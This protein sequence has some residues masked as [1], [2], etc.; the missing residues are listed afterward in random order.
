M[1]IN[2]IK[3]MKKLNTKLNAQFSLFVKQWYA[4]AVFVLFGF[5]LS[6]NAFGAQEGGAGGSEFSRWLWMLVNFSILVAVLVIFLRKPLAAFFANRTE[7]I[8]K[9]LAEAKEA[10]LLAEKALRDIEEKLK[11]KDAEIE[12]IISTAKEMGA[13]DRERL[14]ENGKMLSENLKELTGNNIAYELKR[15]REEVKAAVVEMAVK[16]AEEKIKENISKEQKDQLVDD[17]ITRVGSRN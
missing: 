16:L 10:K 7:L 3:T 13:H 12:K 9:T 2:T 15:A 11:L 5:L 4:V 8:E 17:A 14:I 1:R 6:V